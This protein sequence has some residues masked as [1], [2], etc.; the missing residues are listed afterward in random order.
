MTARAKPPAAVAPKR[1]RF[2]FA[3]GSTAE[4]YARCEVSASG[5]HP[6]IEAERYGAELFAK[7]TVQTVEVEGAMRAALVLDRGP[8]GGIRVRYCPFCGSR[9]DGQPDERG[10]R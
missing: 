5:Y 3:D 2:T 4:G 6:C 7:L 1:Q 8:F 10:A 9:V